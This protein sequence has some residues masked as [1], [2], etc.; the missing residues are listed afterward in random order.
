[1][2]IFSWRADC[3][4]EHE[5]EILV[6][7]R[8]GFKR[9]HVRLGGDDCR[10]EL[11]RGDKFDEPN[12]QILDEHQPQRAQALLR[13]R[14]SI[15]HEIGAERRNDAQMQRPCERIARRRG[16][17][18][19]IS[20][21][22]QCAPGMGENLFARRGRPHRMANTLEDREP[23]LFFQFADLARERRLADVA[24][25]S[26]AAEMAEVGNGDDVAKI[27]QVHV[28]KSQCELGDAQHWRCLSK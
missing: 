20:G 12:G 8:F 26:R 25:F 3:P 24:S 16:D 7:Q 4:F 17:R 15:R 28:R 27:T 23:E 2:L 21:C 13:R 5:P 14:E 19:D 6:E 18:N 10:V 11:A 1:M 9:R 22:R